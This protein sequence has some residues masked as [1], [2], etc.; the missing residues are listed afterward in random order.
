MSLS[1]RGKIAS[2]ATAVIPLCVLLCFST[3][4]L[5]RFTPDAKTSAINDVECI[6]SSIRSNPG[7]PLPKLCGFFLGDKC[8]AFLK[9]ALSE[10]AGKHITQV[11]YYN[12]DDPKY[13][14]RDVDV[15]EVG[16]FFPNGRQATFDFYQGGL[17]QCGEEFPK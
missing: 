12:W 6:L 2:V 3:W 16:V 13:D 14:Y 10:N 15:V 7:A 4:A 9:Q 1:R 5:F 8:A 17:D 11:T